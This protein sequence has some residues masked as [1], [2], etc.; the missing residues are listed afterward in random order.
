[1]TGHPSE[2]AVAVTTLAARPDLLPV[3]AGWIWREWWRRRGHSLEQT[4]SAFAPRRVEFGPPQTFVLLVDGTPVGTATLAAQDL[5]E[6]PDL[7]PWLAAVFVVPEARGRGHARHLLAAFDAACR[8]A[9]VPTAW[10]YTNT[11]ER[12]Y[13]R[14]GWQAVETIHRQGKLPV[15]LMRRD[16]SVQAQAPS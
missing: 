8:A 2:A 13:R 10:L 11:A 3:V 12:V 16:L 9:S 7:S 4:H 1:M 5:E 15:T 14:A 6:R